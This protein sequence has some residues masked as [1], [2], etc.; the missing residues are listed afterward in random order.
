MG[1]TFFHV[2]QVLLECDFGVPKNHRAIQ[3]HTIEN[4]QGL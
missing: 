4:S 2:Q 3:N 1:R